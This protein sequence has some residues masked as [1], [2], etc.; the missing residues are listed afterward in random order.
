M[1]KNDVHLFLII[2]VA[3][4]KQITRNWL[5]GDNLNNSKWKALLNGMGK[6]T[7]RIRNQVYI[8]EEK[9]EKWMRYITNNI[10]ND[11]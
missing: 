6:I 1:R 7:M 2:R 4:I 3:L 11:L 5:K 8:F 10:S 9:W